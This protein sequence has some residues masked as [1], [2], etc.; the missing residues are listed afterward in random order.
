MFFR[1]RCKGESCCCCCCSSLDDSSYESDIESNI[2]V[3]RAVCRTTRLTALS[4]TDRF[5]QVIE[6]LYDLKRQLKEYL[7]NG[8]YLEHSAEDETDY[9]DPETPR[10]VARLVKAILS[11]SYSMGCLA[12]ACDNLV[13]GRR[14]PALPPRRPCN[15]DEARQGGGRTVSAQYMVECLAILRTH[16]DGL[17]ASLARSV[18]VETAA[19]GQPL[20]RLLESLRAL[21]ELG[22]EN[23]NFDGNAAGVSTGRQAAEAGGG[24]VGGGG[25]EESALAVWL[26]KNYFD[27]RSV[28]YI[29]TPSILLG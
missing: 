8:R 9:A 1:R 29:N 18:A 14:V 22:L 13:A 7:E 19:E 4:L 23:L 20:P 5:R 12:T 2:Y 24:G 11:C 10:K 17:A 26:R 21:V 6:Q 27:N 15:P 25:E 3:T 16:V 28:G